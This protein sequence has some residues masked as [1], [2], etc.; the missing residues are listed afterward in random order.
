MSAL[1]VLAAGGTG[2]HMF[3]AEALAGELVGRGVTVA[4]VTDKRG[5]AFDNRLPGVA[6][7]RIRAGRPGAGIAS[8]V[9]AV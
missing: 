2:G 9:L 5:Q 7:H 1:I 3:P 4:L 6:L 8:R